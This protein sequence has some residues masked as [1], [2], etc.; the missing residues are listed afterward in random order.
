MTV[1]DEA[2][3]STLYIQREEV[4]RFHEVT[5]GAAKASLE[6][7]AV[8]RSPSDPELASQ[9]EE[10][11]FIAPSGPGLQRRPTPAARALAQATIAPHRAWYTSD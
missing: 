5:A 8:G 10:H 6:D 3:S 9:L 1:I 11:G 7:L 4:D 2:L